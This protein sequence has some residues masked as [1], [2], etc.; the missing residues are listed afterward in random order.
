MDEA[1]RQDKTEKGRRLLTEIN[2]LADRAR[3][4]GFAT[5]EYI[6]RIAAADVS[7]ELDKA[8]RAD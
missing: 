5:A 2:A 4:S 6:L 8:P 7:K 3:A 1:W